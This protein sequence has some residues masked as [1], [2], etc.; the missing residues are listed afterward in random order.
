MLSRAKRRIFASR[1]MIEVLL[2]YHLGT[3]IAARARHKGRAASPFVLLLIGVWLAGEFVGGGLGLGYAILGN[4][5]YDRD[6]LVL[7][8]IGALIG[9]GLGAYGAFRV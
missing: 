9:A 8:Y 5:R 7:I 4:V 3:R 1:R 6:V 2:L